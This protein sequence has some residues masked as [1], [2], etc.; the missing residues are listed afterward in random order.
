MKKAAL[1]APMLQAASIKEKKVLE[2]I[3]GEDA[4]CWALKVTALLVSFLYLRVLVGLAFP[5]PFFP[6]ALS[7]AC[8]GKV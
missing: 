7:N 3:F 4:S 6:A 2:Y 8:Q 5:G 1:P